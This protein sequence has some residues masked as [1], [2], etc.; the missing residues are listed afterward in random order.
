MILSLDNGADALFSAADDKESLLGS[1]RC[2][3]VS[4]ERSPETGSRATS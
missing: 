1:G 2:D 3:L 4:A